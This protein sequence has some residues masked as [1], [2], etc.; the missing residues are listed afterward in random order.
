MGTVLDFVK[1]ADQKSEIL[2]AMCG[3]GMGMRE[4]WWTGGAP[5]KM[6]KERLLH[7]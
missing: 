7:T 5:N 2:L 6:P 4:L 1:D 3:L